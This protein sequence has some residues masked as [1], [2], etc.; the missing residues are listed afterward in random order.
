MQRAAIM[1][2]T[3]VLIEGPTHPLFPDFTNTPIALNPIIIKNDTPKNTRRSSNI[4]QLIA[5]YNPGTTSAV[6]PLDLPPWTNPLQNVNFHIDLIDKPKKSLTPEEKNN[7][8]TYIE[9][10]VINP[11]INNESNLN[12]FTDGS[13]D[14]QNKTAGAAA[15]FVSNP[16]DDT[17]RP[18]I[19]TF[20]HNIKNIPDYFCEDNDINETFDNLYQEFQY[21]CPPRSG[22]MVTELIS[23]K[24]A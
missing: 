21:M 24:K 23:I 19:D 13:I 6:T 5:Q 20:L 8:K 15:I 1:Y 10:N 4:K 12:I 17:N 18:H 22:S 7:L 14:Q 9:N 16:I 11:N 2:F 3:Q